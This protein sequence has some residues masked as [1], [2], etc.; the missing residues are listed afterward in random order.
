MR[1]RYLDLL[2]RC[3]TGMVYDDPP[4]DPWHGVL[5]DAVGRAVNPAVVGPGSYTVESGA[6]DPVVREAGRDWPKTAATMIGLRRLITLREQIEAVIRDGV[7]GD[8]LEAGVWRGGAVIFMRAVLD[9][10]GA[11]ERRV[12]AADSF[13]GLPPPETLQDGRDP[14]AGFGPLT[15]TLDEVKANFARFG[16]FDERVVFLPGWF[17][18][19]LP[20]PIGP[21]ALLRLDGDMYGSTM[22]VLTACYDRLSPGGYC[23]IDDFNLPPVQQA[24]RDFRRARDLHIDPQVIDR[25]GIFWRKD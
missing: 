4:I 11:N 23:V 8:L 2:A 24:I 6:Y 17:K 20:G 22:D 15:A 10:I 19:T 12:F 25:N 18:D 21:L 13:A 7:P 5:R 3:L 1:D 14:H 9:G 16:L